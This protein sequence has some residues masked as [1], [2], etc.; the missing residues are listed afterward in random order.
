[1]S[2]VSPKLSIRD[3]QL[4]G[5]RLFLRVDYNVPLDGSR[6]TDDT[7]I[8]ETVPT[9]RL[10]LEKG[11]AVILASHLG[12]P[13]G[14]PDPK[15]STKPVA[16]VLA[17]HLGRPV[18]ALGDCVSE[19]TLT[20]CKAL[21][22][23]DVVLLE[24]LRFHPEEQ[25]GDEGFAKKLAALAHE[26]ANDAFGTCHRADASV[27]AL[28]RLFPRPSAGLLIEREVKALG[29]LLRDPERP[30]VAVLGG[31][32]VSDKLPVLKGLLPKVDTM[33]I[34]GAMAYTFLLAE[35][36]RAGGS[37]VEPELVDDVRSLLADAKQ[38]NVTIQ[39]PIDHVVA[40]GITAADAGSAR[41]VA[42][43]F[44]EGLGVDI[45]P[46]TR[47]AYAATLA[48][49]RSIL[50]NGPMGVFEVQGFAGGT[51]A[52]AAAVAASQAFSVVG[53][54]D[55]IAALNQAGLASEVSHVS[56]GGGALL[57]LLAGEEMPGL[58]ALAPAG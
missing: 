3:L 41:V 51:H 10:A 22:P 48:K 55:S 49:A 46:A 44:D 50:W 12:R 21:S 18:E 24:N 23:G 19:E 6:V 14:G 33:L 42:G 37:R 27:S 38:R 34:G 13:K 16:A 20:R 36:Q 28:P 56:T 9:I 45:G 17:S 32:K 7:R 35:G 40:S 30:F 11:A 43:V 8:R 15:Y 2:P 26:Y 54:G 31:A 58:E 39:L 52:V 47:E 53:G 1:M 4:D 29:R 5:R 57:E 25:K